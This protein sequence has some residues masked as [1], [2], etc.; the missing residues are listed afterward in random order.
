MLTYINN[1]IIQHLQTIIKKIKIIDFSISMS[2]THECETCAFFKMYKIVFHFYKKK[3]N[4]NRLFFRIIYD[5]IFMFKNLND[6]EWISH[7]TCSQIDFNL[8]YT[9]KI[10]NETQAMIRHEINLIR[11]RFDEKMIFFELMKRNR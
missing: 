8:I 2:K 11:I 9:H 4:F 1:E 3:Q 6:Y 10:K 7:L 5:L